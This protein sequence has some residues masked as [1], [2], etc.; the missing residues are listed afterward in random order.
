M[1]KHKVLLINKETNRIVYCFFFYFSKY[2]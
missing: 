2:P 1:K